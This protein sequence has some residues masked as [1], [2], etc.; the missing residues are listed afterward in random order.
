MQDKRNRKH[1]PRGATQANEQ[2]RYEAKDCHIAIVVHHLVSAP[3]NN[4]GP[5]SALPVCMPFCM[6]VCILVV[7][8]VFS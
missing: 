6:D 2:P 7:I 5:D 8:Y 3:I 4:S 1:D